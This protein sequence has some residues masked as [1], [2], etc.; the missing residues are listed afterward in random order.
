M[1]SRTTRLSMSVLGSSLRQPSATVSLTLSFIHLKPLLRYRDISCETNIVKKN[2]RSENIYRYVRP[3]CPACLSDISS[4][5]TVISDMSIDRFI[6]VHWWL[7]CI[8]VKM[9][10]SNSLSDYIH[11]LLSN[12]EWYQQTDFGKIEKGLAIIFMNITK[13]IYLKYK[14]FFFVFCA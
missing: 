1:T 3:D 11:L 2:S 14:M 12:I 13:I 6:S 4:V 7:Q 8:R 5:Q 9:L 10:F